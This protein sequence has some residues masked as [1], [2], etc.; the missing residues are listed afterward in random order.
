MTVWLKIYTPAGG[1]EFFGA[2]TAERAEEMATA[3]R[4]A[5]ELTGFRVI[6]PLPG[7]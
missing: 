1:W 6:G 3:A 4:H 7:R 5:Y 2:A